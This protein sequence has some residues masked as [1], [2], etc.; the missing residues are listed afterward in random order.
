MSS[1]HLLKLLTDLGSFRWAECQVVALVENAKSEA[2]VKKSLSTIS[3]SLEGLYTASL[4]ATR[5]SDRHY[6]KSALLW[7]TFA[8]KPL[9]LTE[10]SEAMIFTGASSSID[11]TQRLF[12]D[13]A[14]DI[15]RSCRMLISYNA[16]SKY[17]SLAHSSVQQY[18]VSEQ[19]RSSPA[20]FFHFDKS[21]DLCAL[22]CLSVDYLN[23]TCFAS[24]YCASSKD[25]HERFREWPLLEY[26]SIA[27]PVY[28][29]VMSWPLSS[30]R[31]RTEA[32]LLKFFQS[33]HRPHGGNF[34]SWV[35]VYIPRH[36][37]VNQSLSQPLYYAARSG[38]VE[39]VRM[40]LR[41][42][43]KNMLEVRGGSR[44][45]TA[46]HAACAFGHTEAVQLLLEEG[47]NPN[48]RNEYGERGIE[49][50]EMYGYEDIV[51]LLLEYGASPV[52]QEGL[53]RLITRFK[54]KS[55]GSDNS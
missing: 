46:L 11:P 52:G 31:Q 28:V 50:A 53:D 30:T 12:L 6:L 13:E 47:A 37:N 35:Q 3:P 27:W 21:E 44:G 40:I 38:L 36:L 9:H 10:V 29:K 7:L 48:E 49:W 34:G 14:E 1:C 16:D 19:H 51:E 33:A 25:V 41:V 55:G 39:V 20:G 8:V 5:P 18:L 23:M 26:V 42:E 43:G 45:S 15:L 17:A 54:T 24:G 32:A 4:L 22:S 2:D